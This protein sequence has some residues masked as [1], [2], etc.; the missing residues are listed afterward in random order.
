MY[1]PRHFE[2]TR[3]EVLHALMRAQPLATLVTLSASGDIDANHIP[4]FFSE[5]TGGLGSLRGHVARANPLWRALLEGATA[6]A[7]FHGPD[8]YISPSWYPT[9]REHGR[10]VPTWNYAVVHAHG[11]LRAIDDPAWLRTQVEALTTQQEATFAAPWEVG[12][13]PADFIDRRLEA[14]VGIELVID[15]LTGKFK[16]SQNQPEQNRAGVVAGL[17]DQGSDRALALAALVEEA[18]S[19]REV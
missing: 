16:N 9:K 13:A 6:L 15:K 7:I 12:D 19:S 18:S 10:V 3:P 14:I 11:S 8:G 2:E 1:L 17:E 5:E 4:L